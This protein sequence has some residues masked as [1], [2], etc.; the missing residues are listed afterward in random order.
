MGNTGAGIAAVL[1]AAQLYAQA[2]ASDAV[3]LE[4][5]QVI[6]R[7]IS[8]MQS[9]SYRV[10]LAEGE[11][12][13][14]VV[15]QRGIDVTTTVYDT[16]GKAAA[17]FDFEKRKTGEERVLVVAEA[18]GEYRTAIR[19]AYT[20]AP[21]GRYTVRIAERRAATEP[22]RSAFQA[23]RFSLEAMQLNNAGKLPDAISAAQRAVQIAETALG[24]EDIYVADLLTKLGQI[25]QRTGSY[26]QAEAN[27]TR[28]LR[29][30]EKGL[31]RAH[32]QTIEAIRWLAMVY[33][34]EDEYGKAEPLLEEQIAGIEKTL[35]PEHP[36]MVKALSDL[37]AL[38][39]LRGDKE[40][41][42]A[43]LKQVLA[44][45]EKV[46]APDDTSL[47][48]AINN[49]GDFYSLVKDYQHAE[50]LLERALAMAEKKYG[51]EHYYV[52]IPLQNLGAIART[53][54]HYQRARELLTRAKAIREKTLGGMHQETLSLT[55]NIGNLYS[56]EGNYA[57]ALEL[58][59]EAWEGL[60]R[61]VGPYH[62]LSLMAL[63]N[64]AA[65]YTALGD[66]AHALEYG[67]RYNE[68]LEKNIGMNLAL[69]S[70]REKLAYVEVAFRPTSRTISL[71]LR[72]AP[73]EKSARDLAA[74]V[75]LEQKGRVL[76]AMSGSI[77]ALR[78]RVNQADGALLD[79]FAEANAELARAALGGPGKTS[80]REYETRLQGLENRREQLESAISVRSAEFRAQS[81]PVT[82]AAVSAVIPASAA[83]VEIILFHPYDP[84]LWDGDDAYGDARYAVYVLR[85]DGVTG[86]R[87]LGPAKPIDDAVDALR[88]AL[89]DPRR[90]DAAELARAVDEKVMRPA[91]ALAGDATQLLVS[92]DGDLNLIPFEALIDE[93]G[94]YLLER[95]S[96]SYLTTGRDLLRIAV[97]RPSKTGMVVIANPYFGE[98]AGTDARRAPAAKH[99][100]VTTG[101]DL[102]SVY[103]PPLAGTAAEARAIQSLFPSAAV[104]TGQQ[105]TK[106]SLE[107][108]EAP[109]LLHIATHGFYLQ[110]PEAK[111]A[112][113]GGAP[114]RAIQA[115]AKLENPLLRSGLALAGANLGKTAKENGIL[116]ALEATNLNLWG[117]KLV[118]LSAC[119]SGVGEVKNGEGVYGLRRAFFL[120]GAESMVM[121]LWAVSDRVTQEMMT[122]YYTGLKSGMGRGEALRQAQ[123]AMLKR[124]DRRHPF[125]W[126]SFIQSGDWRN[127]EGK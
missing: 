119:E 107:R 61:T 113:G 46:L 11:C 101:T 26:A 5:G 84:R 112:S 96:I 118:T 80:A 51:P 117:T 65:V 123:L 62:R 45:A 52:S 33:R 95:Y 15:E 43:E 59:R 115:R 40:R 71:N 79:Q 92:P 58:F 36:S 63:A 124:G 122:A 70:E 66:F 29:I 41:A 68:V 89:R 35:G 111:V 53:T 56:S 83:L 37:S 64:I 19:A 31:G 76:D 30:S 98:P 7:E 108:L 2:P 14:L 8:G 102:E 49:L 12:A 24:P 85:R 21:R 103:F 9:H 1:F 87:D 50:P 93:Q 90:K 109:R 47:I 77:S 3:V 88:T 126:A 42:L 17:A 60:V 120:A 110:Q 39:Q 78:R 127:L 100:S 34:L 106:T 57:K 116:T 13:V 105:A 28:A 54:G 69:G 23:R 10:N 55:I 75:S 91:R 104:L 121:S 20:Q 16:D 48:G 97:P 25:E 73:E 22:E 81:Q 38:H 99:R 72:N 82:V 114:T 18:A 74:L 86:A 27:L 4:P 125:Y 32:P 67:T 6:E 44:I 94:R